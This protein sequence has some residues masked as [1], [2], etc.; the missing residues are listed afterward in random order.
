MR[1]LPFYHFILIFLLIG[2]SIHATSFPG[3]G[4]GAPREQYVL[5]SDMITNYS[6]VLSTETSELEVWAAN[7]KIAKRVDIATLPVLYLKCKRSP[8][9]AK[10]DGTFDQ[11][12]AICK[13][14]GITRLSEGG[15]N[16]DTFK[17]SVLKVKQEM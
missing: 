15:E 1:V 4:S 7:E 6:I 8:V 12:L 3:T 10:K 14:E 5:F 2:S 9:D 11:F 16:I 17:K 13:K